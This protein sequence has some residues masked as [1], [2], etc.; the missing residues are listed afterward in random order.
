[1]VE[2][3]AG[4]LFVTTDPF[5]SNRLE[6]ITA[7]ATRYSIPTIYERREF[8]AA[9]GL[10]SYGVDRVE[11]NR[12]AGIYVGR[13]L[14]G[15]KPADLPVQQATKFETCAPPRRSTWTSRPACSPLWTR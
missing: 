4:A 1:M 10:M 5:L 8:P 12:Q 9:G 7:L 13:I 14:K 6:Q 3:Q 11:T 15:E 2:Q